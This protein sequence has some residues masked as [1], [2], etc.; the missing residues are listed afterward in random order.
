MIIYDFDPEPDKIFPRFW[1]RNQARNAV[2]AM[3]WPNHAQ[4]EGVGHACLRTQHQ[5]N[6]RQRR[7]QF[8]ATA[9]IAEA[10]PRCDRAPVVK[11]D[12]S[13]DMAVRNEELDAIARLLGG[14]LDDILSDAGI[15]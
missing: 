4:T 6:P 5:G 8:R 10:P 12:L 11:S 15:E 2:T 9:A 7:T 3:A 1:D 13:G 14:A